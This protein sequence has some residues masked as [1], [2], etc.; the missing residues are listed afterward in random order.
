VGEGGVAKKKNKKDPH[1]AREAKKY[2]SPVASREFIMQTLQDL[3]APTTKEDLA[4][5]FKI[6]SADEAEGLRRRLRAMER[7]GQLMRTRKNAY[8]LISQM[9]LIAGRVIGHRDGYGFCVPDDGGSDLFLSEYQMRRVFTDDRVLVSASSDSKRRKRE[10]RIVEVLERNTKELVGKFLIEDKVA[11]VCADDKTI[12]QDILILPDGIGKAEHGQFVIVN[13]VQQ[14]SV[15]HQAIGEVVNVLGDYLTPGME[16]DLALRSYN[17]PFKWPDDVLASAKSVATTVKAK[18]IKGRLDLRELPFCTIDGADARD[19]DDAVFCAKTDIGWCLY[20]AIADVSYYVQPNSPLD[21]EALKRGNSVYFPS[22]VIPMLPESLSNEM[23]SLKPR[24]DRLTM[25]CKMDIDSDGK[26]VR[27]SFHNSVIHSHERFTYTEVA[28]ML[29]SKDSSHPLSKNIVEF[30]SLYEKL[31]LQRKLRGAIEFETTETRMVFD[32]DGKIEKIVPVVRNDAHKMIE[33][34]MLLANVCAAQFALQAKHPCLYRSHESPNDDKI[35][36]LRD[37]MNSFGLKLSGGDEP[38]PQ[39]FCDLLQHISGRPDA[40]LLQTVLLR[41][42][43]QAVYS[44]DNAGHFGLSFDGYTHFTS[45][46][47]RYPDLLVHRAIKQ[48]I[49]KNADGNKSADEDNSEVLYKM[50]QFAEHCS[51]TERRADRAS[52]SA[53]DWLKCFFMQDKVGQVFDGYIVDVTSFGI[54]VE[55]RDIYVQGLVHI[56]ALEN[57]YYLH[58]QT[59]HMLVGQHGGLKYRLGDDIKIQVARVDLDNRKIDFSLV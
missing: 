25:V 15:R 27:Y 49:L 46:I 45:P 58:D 37:F 6:S 59:K 17:L 23:C 10:G 31:L 52:R 7:D 3:G 12:S 55:L 19:F 51:M 22:K 57:D 48:I 8:A 47:R 14:P 18:E 20:V 43:S 32:D 44:T 13:I 39:D 1:L 16:V 11:F 42:L 26:L 4:E 28:T 41:S 24:V 2:D 36:I 9:N 30:Y 21:K 35:A 50:Q 38:S 40:T 5:I 53:S 34:A 29:E 56:T 54:F 33:E